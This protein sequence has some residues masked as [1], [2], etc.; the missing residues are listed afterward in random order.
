MNTSYLSEWLLLLYILYISPLVHAM[1][2]FFIAYTLIYYVA[3]LIII[4]IRKYFTT[5]LLVVQ[6]DIHDHYVK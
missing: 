4:A 2:F 5:R 3:H 1:L 6:Y